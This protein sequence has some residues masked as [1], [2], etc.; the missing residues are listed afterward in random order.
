MTSADS[1]RLPSR[2]GSSS[3]P[4]GSEHLP[5]ET[6]EAGQRV[7]LFL[8]MVCRLFEQSPL[9]QMIVKGGFNS[10]NPM[11][12]NFAFLCKVSELANGRS[13][14]IY[15]AF[16][17]SDTI[18]FAKSQSIFKSLT[19]KFAL[20]HQTMHLLRKEAT[21]IEDISHIASCDKPSATSHSCR[22]QDIKPPIR[23]RTGPQASRNPRPGRSRTQP[24]Q[25]PPLLGEEGPG[26]R[27]TP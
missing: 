14:L 2:S 23:P 16:C 26:G 5:A 19:M 10:T 15:D 21:D 11:L 3:E 20:H 13:N 1:P 6:E 8:I 4:F 24:P 12:T 27:I 17:L 25:I 22:H 7:G 9:C 18:L